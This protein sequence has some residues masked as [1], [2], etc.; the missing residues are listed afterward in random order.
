MKEGD[1][2]AST[3]N[4]PHLVHIFRHFQDILQQIQRQHQVFLLHSFLFFFFYQ[5][6]HN[7]DGVV[8]YLFYILLVSQLCCVV[9]FPILKCD[10]IALPFLG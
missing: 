6:D 10:L 8:Q 9:R 7:D 1:S 4:H 2:K 3:L 5:M